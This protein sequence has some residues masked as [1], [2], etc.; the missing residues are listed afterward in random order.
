MGSKHIEED[1]VT[2]TQ[3]SKLCGM[4]SAT[5]TRWCIQGKIPGAVFDQPEGAQHRWL[6]PKNVAADPKWRKFKNGADGRGGA[7]RKGPYTEKPRL[8]GSMTLVVRLDSGDANGLLAYLG[9]EHLE[10]ADLDE[11]VISI[12]P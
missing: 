9:I 10:A 7:R 1:V 6:I 2:T 4:H 11:L 3:M 5:I 12:N 8:A